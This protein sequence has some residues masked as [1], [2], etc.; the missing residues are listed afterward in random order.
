M[1]VD[2]LFIYLYTVNTAG[3]KFPS[4]GYVRNLPLGDRVGLHLGQNFRPLK[5]NNW[6]VKKPGLFFTVKKLG[7]V[8]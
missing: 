3:T 8:K 4:R 6:A 1:M 2:L 5:C 7:N